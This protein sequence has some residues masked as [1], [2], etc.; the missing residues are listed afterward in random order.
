MP[1][2]QREI[3]SEKMLE[4]NRFLGIVEGAS[5]RIIFNLT[6]GAF[7][8]G[9]LKYMGANDTV[10]GYI[11]AIPVLAAVIQFLSPIVLES[12]PYRKTIIT[13]G[14]MVHR[15]LLTLLIFAPFL[16]IGVNAKLWVAGGMFFVSYLAVSFVNPAISNM[17]VSFV[18]PNIRG[19]YFG[20]RESYCLLAATIVTLILGK[21]LDIYT[22]SGMETTGYIIIY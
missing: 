8:V 10:C 5:A 1:S 18:P 20:Q 4:K 13:I 19:K 9:L 11:I 2:Q 17:Y 7:L 6:S 22:D 16:P 3:P 15:V 21:V 12:L 14:S